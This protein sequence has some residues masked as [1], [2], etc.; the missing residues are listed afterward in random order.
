MAGIDLKSKQWID[1]VFDGR[2]KEYG[3]YQLRKKYNK[4]AILSIIIGVIGVGLLFSIPIIASAIKLNNVKEDVKVNMETELADIDL[5][6][7]KPPPP[8]DIP[9]P[10]PPPPAVKEVK[11]TPPK[12]VKQDQIKKEDIPPPVETIE[13]DALIGDETVEEGLSKF[14]VPIKPPEDGEG[15]EKIVGAVVDNKVYS[16]ASIQKKPKFPGNR[17]EFIRKN[18][19]YPDIAVESGIEGIVYVE[20]TV[21]RDGRITNIHVKRGKELGFGLAEEAVRI[22]KLMPKWQPG[23]ING[24]KVR[25]SFVQPFVFKLQ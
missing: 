25:V 3:A 7:K 8:P 11:F 22:I 15:T 1:M 9:P 5:E 16:Y 19:D 6:E 18:I 14:D 10:P 17:M 13:E 23:E 20:F 4:T 24:H 2:N 21:E 12:I